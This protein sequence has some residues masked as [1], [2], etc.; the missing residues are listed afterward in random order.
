[1]P[2]QREYHPSHKYRTSIRKPIPSHPQTALN[3]LEIHLLITILLLLLLLLLGLLSLDP[4]SGG[5]LIFLALAIIGRR[6]GC[7]CSI[8][9]GNTGNI[10]VLKLLILVFIAIIAV[11]VFQLVGFLLRFLGGEGSVVLRDRL[12]MLVGVA[13]ERGGRRGLLPS[14]PPP[15]S[16]TSRFSSASASFRARPMPSRSR[17]ALSA[18]SLIPAFVICPGTTVLC[19]CHTGKAFFSACCCFLSCSARSS[20]AV[21]SLELVIEISIACCCAGLPAL[22]SPF[23]TGTNCALANEFLSRGT[24]TEF[25]IALSKSFSGICTWSTSLR[26]RSIFSI[27][28]FMRWIFSWPSFVSVDSSSSTRALL[29][30]SQRKRPDSS[31]SSVTASSSA[32]R[33]EQCGHT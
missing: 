12:A 16:W 11:V 4:L 20:S 19:V 18:A 1:M 26:K 14:P 33:L 2:A 6:G 22:P 23:P 9:R 7:S 15:S 17:A 31:N 8:G 32:K 28:R 30:R 25:A 21:F 29:Q 5:L 10:Q 27:C 24:G 13:R 3:I